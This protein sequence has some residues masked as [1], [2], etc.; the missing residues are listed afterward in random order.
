MP[1]SR[2]TATIAA[3]IELGVPIVQAA[4]RNFADRADTLAVGFGAAECNR[5]GMDK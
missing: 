4:L 5:F 2:I 1:R 3:S